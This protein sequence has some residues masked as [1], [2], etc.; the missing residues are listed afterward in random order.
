MTIIDANGC[1]GQV[2]FVINQPPALQASSVA[3]HVTCFGYSDGRV[4]LNVNGGVQPYQYAWSNGVVTSANNAIP[5]GNYTCTITDAH[6]CTVS[7][8]AQVQEP[9][10]L[11][12]SLDANSP[13]CSGINN[14]S[15]ASIVSGGTGYYT[16][17][18]STG[19][20]APSID[21]LAPGDYTVNIIDENACLVQLSASLQAAEAFTIYLSTS[22]TLICNGEQAIIEAS[23]S[24][25]HNLYSYVWDH[26]VTGA[27]FGANPQVTTTYT[28]LVQDSAGCIGQDSITIQVNQIPQVSIFA[29]DS[30][31]CMPFCAKL[32]AT[33]STATSFYWTI[34]D[35]MTYSG[36]NPVPCFTEPGLYPVTVRVKDDANCSSEKIWTELIRVYPAPNA[37]FTPV[38]NETTLDQPLVNFVNQSEGANAYNYYFG[39]PYNSS[40]FV[41]N[42]AFTFRDTG[43]FEV[44]LQVG[45][46]Y[47]CTDE[48]VQT[49]HIGGFKAFYVPKAFTPNADGL[50]D[51]FLPKSS[52]FA[53]EGFEMRIFDRWGHE[54]FFSDSW[55]KGWDGTVDGRPVPVD[56]YVCKIRYYDK[57]GNGNNHIGAVTVTE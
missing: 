26:G 14:G 25:I 34:A 56:L 27:I 20:Q 36:P 54:V 7:T 46:E 17:Q 12:A 44:S 33:S 29:D 3:Q 13:G 53:S 28:V 19:Q 47:G 37:A 16:Y 57:L 10:Q 38:P 21:G 43:T 15:I 22:D 55:E 51:V 18:W 1:A 30:S 31:G 40:V 48:T 49:I 42:T 32:H 41:E 4:L 23:A 9:A 39:D 6:G 45:N 50:N 35:S 5:A 11:I 2:G 24:G 8:S 52:G